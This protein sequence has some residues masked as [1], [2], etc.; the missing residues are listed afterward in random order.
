M[1]RGQPFTALCQLA[2]RLSGPRV[3]DLHV[4]TTASDGDYT[5]SQ[6]VALARQA[7][8]RAVAI[9]DHDTLAG[10]GLAAEAAGDVLEVIPGVEMSAEF[11]GRE[12]H[13][14]GYFIRP[15][16]R[17]LTQHLDAVCDRRRERFRAFIARL[18]MAG[19]AFPNGL[20]E[21]EAE[22][23]TSLGRRHLA[24]LLVRT[25]AARSRF[26]AFQRFLLPITPDVPATH[27]T[28][29]AEVIRLVRDAGGVCSLAHPP[30]GDEEELLTGLRGLDLSAVE[31][32]FPAAAVTRT[33][34]LRGL[35]RK[36]GL[37]VTGGSDCHGPEAAGRTVG[38]RGVTRDELDALRRLAGSAVSTGRARHVPHA[39]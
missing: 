12:V 38:A 27:L 33:E 39:G 18:E 9:T 15:D 31:A 22:R 4:H 35:A 23:S 34:R 6:V 3:A 28:A 7:R 25:G 11:A 20:A 21:L 10:V 30:E 37:A 17:R 24:G 5:A 2:A 16:D 8:L 32:S 29:A 1:P 14:L 13:I 19:V 36:L 26:G